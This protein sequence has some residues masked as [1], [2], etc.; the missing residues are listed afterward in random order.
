MIMNA[1]MLLRQERAATVELLSRLDPA[2]WQANT[3]CAGWT[4]ADLAAH[5]V[6]RETRPVRF[7][8]SEVSKGRLG[9]AKPLMEQAKARG[10]AYLL[11]QL[12][13]GPPLLYRTPGPAAVANFVENWVHNQDFQRGELNR[14]QP[15][16]ADAQALLWSTLHILGRMML[17][18]IS[19][20]GSVALQQPDGRALAFRVGDGFP[21]R[22]AADQA[23]A[24]MVG[25]PGELVLFLLGR[26]SAAKVQISGDTLLTH[27]LHVAEMAL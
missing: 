21:R 18:T 8:L 3:L 24:H 12:R 16:S 11:Q 14:P 2:A 10:H 17:R 4:V 5:L 25:E 20:P 19:V 6:V 23:A 15:T 27:A 13:Q 1:P 26:K 7:V 9:P 22:I